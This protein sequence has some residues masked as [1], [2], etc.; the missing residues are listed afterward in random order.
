[1]HILFYQ[2]AVYEGS[3]KTIKSLVHEAEY[4]VQ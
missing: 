4:N 1:M 2:Q 3:P